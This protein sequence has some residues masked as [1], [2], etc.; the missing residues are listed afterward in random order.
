MGEQAGE[1]GIASKVENEAQG[2]GKTHTLPVAYPK[3][4]G[5]KFPKKTG[6]QWPS[7]YEYR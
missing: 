5:R 4:C 1:W 7:F 6:E 3:D 2:K